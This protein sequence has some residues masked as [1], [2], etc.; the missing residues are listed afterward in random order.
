M[1]PIQMCGVLGIC[2]W[3]GYQSAVE[4][5]GKPEKYSLA[6]SGDVD[7]DVPTGGGRVGG[8]QVGLSGTPI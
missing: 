7:P 3:F 1:I 6:P 2:N 4:G 8:N 5:F